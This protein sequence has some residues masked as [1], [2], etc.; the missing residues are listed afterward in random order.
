MV[1]A[2]KVLRFIHEKNCF[3]A[4]IFNTG[5]LSFKDYPE[6]LELIS[7]GVVAGGAVRDTILNKPVKDIDIYIPPT[8]D[9]GRIFSGNLA[10]LYDKGVKVF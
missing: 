8:P 4:G 6:L 9:V 1:V 3:R 5:W 2:E 7:H 10:R